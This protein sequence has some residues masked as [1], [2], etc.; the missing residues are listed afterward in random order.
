L[1]W[2]ECRNRCGA[3]GDPPRWALLPRPSVAQLLILSTAGR[4]NDHTI[5]PAGLRARGASRERLLASLLK[6]G[7]VE[8]QTTRDA[9]LSW[10]RDERRQRYAL[11][12]SEA[13]LAAVGGGEE[14]APAPKPPVDAASDGAGCPGGKLGQI[15]NAIAAEQGATLA[16]LVALTGWQPHTT[17]AAL[18][19][20]RQR[21][22]ALRLVKREGRSA[23]HRRG[24]SDAPR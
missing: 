21:G 10:R 11:R 6:R 16:E 24:V 9:A 18:T 15:L 13:G 17:R 3:L 8:E 22:F 19:R 2:W 7:L 14:A 4:P 1:G 20:L 23:Y 12:L 5:L